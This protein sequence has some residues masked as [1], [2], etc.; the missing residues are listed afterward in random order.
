[1]H[2]S[3]IIIIMYTYI[4]TYLRNNGA[5]CAV[6]NNTILCNKNNRIAPRSVNEL[7]NRRRN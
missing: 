6:N 3:N 5:T 7:R 2:I 1:M 4:N